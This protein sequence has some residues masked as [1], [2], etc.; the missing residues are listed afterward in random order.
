MWSARPQ[1]MQGRLAHANE[2]LAPAY[3]STW[4]HKKQSGTKHSPHEHSAHS[5]RTPAAEAAHEVPATSAPLMARSDNDS[6]DYRCSVDDAAAAKDAVTSSKSASKAIHSNSPEH[7]VTQQMPSTGHSLHLPF[8]QAT[9]ASVNN[10]AIASAVPPEARARAEALDDRGLTARASKEPA[11][12][13][14]YANLTA[15]QIKPLDKFSDFLR[16]KCGSLTV[17]WDKMDTKS[18]GELSEAEFQ[19]VVGH[20]LSYGRRADVRRLFHNLPKQDP[21]R[22]TWRDIGIT[23][24]EWIEYLTE[25]KLRALA[26]KGF[27]LNE[28]ARPRTQ[29]DA[30]KLHLAF[31]EKPPPPVGPAL[32]WSLRPQS[33]SSSTRPGSARSKTR[34]GLVPP[35]QVARPVSSGGPARRPGSAGPKNLRS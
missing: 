18:A 34:M 12:V 24:Q 25:K 23:P 30:P 5:P 1:N 26:S 7:H 22:L 9:H 17:A 4:P 19:F 14:R 20:T 21:K 11:E 31:G 6:L 2:H 16:E 8:E 28:D 29:G 32:P 10:G 35:A 33:T 15:L 13:G 27:K 3:Q